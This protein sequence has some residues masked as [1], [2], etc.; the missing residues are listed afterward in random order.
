MFYYISTCV[1]KL[2]FAL[3]GA[4]TNKPAAFRSRPWELR[5]IRSFD[6]LDSLN[7]AVEFN[8]RDSAFIRVLP[9]ISSLAVTDN[10]W[11]S[12]RIR[13]SVDAFRLQDRK[14]T[15]LNSSH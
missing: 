11:I 4:L 10:E 15:R 12:D 3:R 1:F 14:S 9:A 6:L 8:I 5:S 7:S 2:N 13:Y